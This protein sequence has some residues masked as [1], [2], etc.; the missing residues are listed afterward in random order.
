MK[1]GPFTYHRPV[2]LAEA[3]DV[4][5]AVG[6]DGKVLAGGQSLLPLLSMR[7]ASPRNVIDV[8]AVPGLDTVEVTDGVVRVGALVRHSDLE[9]HDGAARAQP[10]LRQALRLVAHPTIRNRGTTVGSICHAD[11]AAEMPAVLVLLGGAV[12]ARSTRGERRVPA[13]ELFAGPLESTLAPDELAVAAEF[14]VAQPG[15]RSAVLEVSRR[16]GDYAVCGVAVTIDVGA[17]GTVRTA[18]AGYVSMGLTPPVVDVSGTVAGAVAAQA[19]W[20][21]AAEQAVAQL[22]PEGDIH[23]SADYR[24]H[25]ARTLTERAFAQAVPGTAS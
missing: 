25:L 14:P 17:D 24:A 10:L 15:S 6:A 8:N 18:R 22:E 5:A 4:L 19:P 16:H 3:L 13:A 12:V 2:G 7:L 21:A 20:A 1:P 9:R 11:P 23:A